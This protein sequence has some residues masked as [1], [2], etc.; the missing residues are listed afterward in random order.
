MTGKHRRRLNKIRYARKHHCALRDVH[1]RQAIERFRRKVRP[2][3]EGRG[4]LGA[5]V[6]LPS[7]VTLML[8]S[9]AS[10]TLEGNLVLDG[11]VTGAYTPPWFRQG[12]IRW[13]G[14]PL[15]GVSPLKRHL[16]AWLQRFK[17]EERRDEGGCDGS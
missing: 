1:A 9:G 16:H 12:S 17:P 5:D 13:E 3:G 4:V 7:N 15:V 11:G 6:M 2:E 8:G 14:P 10:L